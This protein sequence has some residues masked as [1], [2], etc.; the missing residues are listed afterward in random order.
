MNTGAD[1]AANKM[2]HGLLRHQRGQF[3]SA[4]RNSYT[5]EWLATIKNRVLMENNVE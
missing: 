5:L 4:P 3:S 2:G 1:H